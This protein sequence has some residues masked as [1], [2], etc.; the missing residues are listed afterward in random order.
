[1]PVYEY[2]CPVCQRRQDAYFT[3]SEAK[4]LNAKPPA[5][6]YTMECLHPQLPPGQRAALRPAAM[7]RVLSLTAP[8]KIGGLEGKLATAAKVRKR[9]ADHA[10]SKRG[11]E[12]H[13]AN[14]FAA[15]KRLGIT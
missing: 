7:V 11:Q 13:R 14:V 2:E 3:Q 12:E 9:N 15:H 10:V 8:P 4:Q 6:S 5:L 1:M